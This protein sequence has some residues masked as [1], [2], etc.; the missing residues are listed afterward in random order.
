MSQ[1]TRAQDAFNEAYLEGMPDSLEGTRGR[2]DAEDRGGEAIALG[3]QVITPEGVRKGWVRIEDGA[4]A[5]ITQT[6]AHEAC[7]RS[8]PTA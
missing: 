1:E 8:R 4:I 7:G 2:A 3:G 6:Q 5:A